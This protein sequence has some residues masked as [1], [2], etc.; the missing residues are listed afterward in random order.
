[1]SQTSA[2]AS[3]AAFLSMRSAIMLRIAA[4]SAGAVLPHPG[5]AACA[6]SSALSMSAASERGTSQNGWAV[7][8]VGFSK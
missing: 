8:G 1:M 5:A 6:A 7:T 2:T 3:A 4:R